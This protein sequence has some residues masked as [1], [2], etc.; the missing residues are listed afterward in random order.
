MKQ[1]GSHLCTLFLSLGLSVAPMIA[2]A[3]TNPT[4]DAEAAAELLEAATLALDE[5]HE[6]RDRVKAL[7]QTVQAYE[8]G[9]RAMREGLRRAAIRQQT[10]EQELAASEGEIAQLLGVLQSMGQTPTPITLL[11]P[12]G[13]VGTARSGMILAD[14]TPTLNEQA[15]ALRAKLDDLAVL[16]ALQQSA[17]GRLQDGL[18]GAQSARTALS[19]A[20]ADRTDLPR[21]FTEDPV[22]TALLIA[23]TESLTGFASGLSQITTDD[24]AVPLPG[25]EDR[26]GTL[27]L[28]VQ[29]RILRDAGEADAAGIT[30]PGILVAAPPR[31][32]VTTPA[33]ATLRYRGPLLDYGTVAILEPQSGILLVLAGMDVVYGEIGQVL[34]M[35][36]PVGLMGGLDPGDDGIVPARLQDAG[37]DWTETLYIEVRQDNT[38]VDPALWFRTDKDD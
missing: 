33:A 14:V 19:Q 24:Q 13:P 31:A 20:I 21:R 36:S 9:L 10:L 27:P 29:G 6:A 32:L 2:H 34:P 37:S 22:K 7:T 4:A 12:T 18:N 16:R 30:R 25:I 11:H 15:R 38:P 26:K 1:Y 3:Q 28:P 5:A 35:N 23:S 17:A 8:A